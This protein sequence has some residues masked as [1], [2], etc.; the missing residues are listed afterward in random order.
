MPLIEIYAKSQVLAKLPVKEFHEFLRDKDMFNVPLDVMQ[1]MLIP[2]Q[3]LYPKDFYISIRCKGK[4]DRTPEKIAA[5]LEKM[6]EW[7]RNRDIGKNGKIRLER[8]EPSLQ[9]ERKLSKL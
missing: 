7:L 3:E 5:I 9:A 8:Y 1:I 2:V 4:A 6:D